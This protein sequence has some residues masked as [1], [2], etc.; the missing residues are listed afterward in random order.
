MKNTIAGISL[1]FASVVCVVLFVHVEYRPP[2]FH[3][4]GNAWGTGDGTRARSTYMGGGYGCSFPTGYYGYGYPNWWCSY[5]PYE[6]Y[7]PPVVLPD[8]NDESVKAIN[9]V[10]DCR[11][12][13]LDIDDMTVFHDLF[14]MIKNELRRLELP[15]IHI[16]LDIAAL[17]DANEIRSSTIVY[18]EGMLTFPPI[19]LRSMLANLLEPLELD[20]TIRNESLLITTKEQTHRE[21]ALKWE[22]EQYGKRVKERQD[23]LRKIDPVRRYSIFKAALAIAW[24]AYFLSGLCLF[25][26]ARKRTGGFASAAPKS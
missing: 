10:L 6:E 17:K 16:A 3:S 2:R 22:R 4:E 7:L 18:P 20:Y 12:I 21:M 11:D 15:D 25:L 1:I 19:R 5:Y 14:P 13:R 9:A 24:L 8:P 26:F 23:R